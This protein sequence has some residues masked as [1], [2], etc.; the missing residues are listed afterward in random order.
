MFT[1]PNCKK[2]S[3]KN[4]E[5][6]NFCKLKLAATNKQKIGSAPLA[7]YFLILGALV[8]V[9]SPFNSPLI[10]LTFLAFVFFFIDLSHQSSI[11]PIT[12]SKFCGLLI[13]WVALL[14]TVGIP[15][16]IFGI[17]AHAVGGR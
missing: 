1:C 4:D 14:I 10:A 7:I 3:F 17:L 9:S 8:G 15:A 11:K 2:I 5:E 12:F 16:V 13:G 6:C